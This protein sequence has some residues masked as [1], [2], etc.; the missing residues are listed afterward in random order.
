MSTG[1][2]PDGAGVEMMIA[3]SGLDAVAEN[4]VFGGT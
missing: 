3:S 2:P 1:A 4:G